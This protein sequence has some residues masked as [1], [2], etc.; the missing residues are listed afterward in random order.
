MAKTLMEE[1]Q[2]LAHSEGPY[3]NWRLPTLA[4]RQGIHLDEAVNALASHQMAVGH[5][6]N[7]MKGEQFD[8]ARNTLRT[9]RGK[10]DEALV[11]LEPKTEG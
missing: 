2:Q 3:Q 8:E 1:M 11:A 7:A 4:E 6:L 9:L 5:A 10:I